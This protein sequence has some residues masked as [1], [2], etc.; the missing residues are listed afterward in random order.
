MVY[1]DIEGT[2]GGK[3]PI[4]IYGHLDKQPYFEGWRVEEGIK[5]TSPILKGDFLYGRGAND[6]G[7]ASFSALGAIKLLQE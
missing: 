7:Y 6:D 2:S 4:L 5:P 1:I 3:Q